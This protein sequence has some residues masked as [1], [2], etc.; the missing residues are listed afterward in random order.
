M[1]YYG[2]KEIAES[3]RT[4]RK[5]T[6]QVA[7]DIPEEK[8]SYR[9]ATDTMSVAEM[10]AHLATTPHWAQQCFFVE[11]K[12]QVAMED[13]GRWM[14][15]AT[16]KSKALT[17]KAAI[18]EALKTNG[19]E[20]AKHLESMT[21]DAARA[22]D[23]RAER[24]QVGVRDADRHQGT[25]DASSRAALP[26][27]AHG[28]HRSPPD[29]RPHGAHGPAADRARSPVTNHRPVK[30]L[31]A[32][33]AF[34]DLIFVGLERLPELGEE[35]K[36]DRFMATIG[37]GAVITSVKAARLGMRTQ[38]ISAL[39]D[40]AVTRLKTERVAVTN[41]RKKHE[42]HA[43]TAALSTGGD[44]AFVTFNGVNSTIGGAPGPAD[45]AG[46]GE[47]RPPLFLSA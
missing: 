44:R 20:F 31:C 13:F 9:A 1:T 22:A 17:S 45:P 10:L 38:L 7:E 18:V 39:S 47:S 42:P 23:R 15:E 21:E 4:V 26:D 29:P 11:K 6:I 46:Q 12:T 28:R 36:T 43:I 35:I 32:G 33:E 19:E 8:Y 25:R 14:G 37:G 30:L 27:R 34:E 40:V 3:F 5:N 2:A 24:Q 16:A 41:L